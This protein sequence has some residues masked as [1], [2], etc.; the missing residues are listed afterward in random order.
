[1]NYYKQNDSKNIHQIPKVTKIVLN[2]GIGEA[3][4]DEKILNKA[5]EELTLICGQKAIMTSAKKAI[6]SFKIRAG[7]KIGVRATLRND[8]CLLYTSDAAD[9]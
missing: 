9:E 3:K 8:I 2:M 4:E 6:S 7:M 1:M 5:Q